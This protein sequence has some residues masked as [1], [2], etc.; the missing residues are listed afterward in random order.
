[1][2]RLVIEVAERLGQLVAAIGEAVGSASAASS[3]V[4]LQYG[5]GGGHRTTVD[6]PPSGQP[7]AAR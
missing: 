6:R 3:D 1:M 4:G 2:G 7:R 5:V